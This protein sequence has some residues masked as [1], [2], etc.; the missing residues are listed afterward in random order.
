[1]FISLSLVTSIGLVACGGDDMMGDDGPLGGSLT[2]TGDVVD[3]RTGTA[4]TASASITTSGLLPAPQVSAQGA[5]FTITGIPENSAFQIF[6]GAPPTHRSTFSQ[7]I[8]VQSSDVNGVKAPAVSEAYLTSLATGFN[9]T[10]TAARGVLFVR[11]IDSNGVPKAGVAGANFPV[12]GGVIG[13]KFLDANMMPSTAT[14]SSSSGYAVF[15]EVPPG[16]VSFAQAAAATVTVDMAVSPINAGSVTIADAKIID[17]A[18]VLPTNVSF[19]TSVYP[20]FTNRGCVACHSGGG[21]GKDL[22]GLH[23]DGGANLA[24]R[25]LVTEKPNTRVQTAMPEKS[26]VLTFPSRE[27]PPDRHPNITFAGPTDPDYLK[28]LVWIREGARN[29]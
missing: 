22:G 27:D 7:A 20:I 19:I 5:S 10:P 8:V 24:Y 9:I 1:M 2:V 18:P 26:W 14:S 4:I 12:S 21:P 17:G 25:E 6:A 29:N 16:V 11:L 13:P 23:L 15:F 3:F 28:L